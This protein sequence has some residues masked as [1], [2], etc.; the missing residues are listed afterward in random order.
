MEYMN[1]QNTDSTNLVQWMMPHLVLPT[2]NQIWHSKETPG[3]AATMP[4]TS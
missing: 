1:Q 3:H 2:T 4:Q